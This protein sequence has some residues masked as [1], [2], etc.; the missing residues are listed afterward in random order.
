MAGIA[1]DR[2][3]RLRGGCPRNGKDM[4]M[5]NDIRLEV[6]IKV[7]DMYR[8]L[9]YNAYHGF[10]ALPGLII[11]AGALALLI[12]GFADSAFAKAML[13][14][15][16]ALFTVVNPLQL[17]FK[18]ARQVVMT[19]AFKKPLNYELNDEG[20]TV[21][22]DQEEVTVKWEDFHKAVYKKH[23]IYLYTSAVYANI[24]PR[25]SCGDAWENV[26]LLIKEKIKD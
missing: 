2:D 8:F 14:I 4:Q 6:K 24:L 25:E 13:I 7:V 22:Q 15:L 1:G 5:G 18:A 19:P 23:A 20:V 17:Y 21:S 16:V 3:A 9:L 10:S 26:T 12:G 11:S